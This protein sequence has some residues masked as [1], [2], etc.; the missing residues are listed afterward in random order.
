MKAT[1]KEILIYLHDHCGA[2]MADIANNLYPDFW[3]TEATLGGIAC[4]E[5][6]FLIPRKVNAG[7]S[8]EY[9]VAHATGDGGHGKSL[10]QIDDRSYPGF[11]NSHPL[12]DIRAYIIKAVE[13]LIEKDKAIRNAGFTPENMGE[14]NFQTAVI[15]AY[16]SGQGNVI[17]SLRAGKDPNS[18]TFGGDYGKCVMEYRYIYA[19]MYAPKTDAGTL[20]VPEG[21][22]TANSELEVAECAKAEGGYTAHVAEDKPDND[23]TEPDNFVV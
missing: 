15:C 5:Y 1:N 14:V 11:V 8:F 6:G 13:C 20:I 12:S 7:Q 21:Y 23:L 9:I 3:V 10:W 16:N 22:E 2:D 4:R 18:R 17:K 19:D